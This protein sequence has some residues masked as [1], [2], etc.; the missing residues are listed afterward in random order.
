VAMEPPQATPHRLVREF[1]RR[2]QTSGYIWQQRT[3]RLVDFMVALVGLILISPLLLLIALAIKASSPGPIFYQSGRLGKHKQ[4]FFML[5]F[6]TMSV[7]A[8]AQRD[9]LRRE[10]HLENE[11]F[12]LKDDPR[13]TPIGKFLRQ[14]SL[15]ELPQLVNVLVGDM[16]LVGPRPL[17]PDE[18][19]LFSAPF[20][21][22]Y[23]VLPG[24]TG[25]WQVGG[26]SNC[27]FHQLCTLEFDY[28]IGWHLLKDFDLLFST[29]PA[30][31]RCNGAY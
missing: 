22:R 10:Q 4:P 28:L 31:L 25:A 23:Q 1:T 9:K 26:R 15:D 17:P 12:K 29:V 13:V 21:I 30:V 18:S 19:D 11:L 7:D 16:S 27:S 14:Y 2:Q 6:R 8:D 24:I 20:T 5:K 3:K